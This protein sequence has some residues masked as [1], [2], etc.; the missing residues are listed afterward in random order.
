MTKAEHILAIVKSGIDIKKIEEFLEPDYIPK[1]SRGLNCPIDNYGIDDII[2]IRGAEPGMRC[3]QIIGNDD[4]SG[5]LYCGE[6]AYL[7]GWSK[8]YPGIYYIF[9]FGHS[10]RYNLTLEE[11]KT[12]EA[13]C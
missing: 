8:A 12:N 2:D 13:D 4:Q 11:K 9:C 5:P 10:K 7:Y 1:N 6:P 3:C